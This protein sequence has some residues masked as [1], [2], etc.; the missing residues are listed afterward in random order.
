MLGVYDKTREQNLLW[1]FIGQIRILHAAQI[2]IF[3]VLLISDKKPI[4]I[5]MTQID[6]SHLQVRIHWLPFC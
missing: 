1:A 3:T 6:S 4:E 5:S 2:R